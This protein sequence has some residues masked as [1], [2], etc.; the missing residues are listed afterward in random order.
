MKEDQAVVL[1]TYC[2][3]KS[4]RIVSKQSNIWIRVNIY[5]QNICPED[6][7]EKS[8]ICLINYA[9]LEHCMSYGILACFVLPVNSCTRMH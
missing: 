9:Y 2:D 4:F 1:L 3:L 7:P 5:W 6:D 8:C